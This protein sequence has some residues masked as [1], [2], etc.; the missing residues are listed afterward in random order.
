M[1]SKYHL[2]KALHSFFHF[3]KIIERFAIPSWEVVKSTTGKTFDAKKIDVQVMNHEKVHPGIWQI[4]LTTAEF[5][6]TS[7]IRLTLFSMIVNEAERAKYLVAVIRMFEIR[8][9]S[10]VPLS[11]SIPLPKQRFQCLLKC[12]YPE[13]RYLHYNRVNTH[14]YCLGRHTCKGE[15]Y[16]DQQLGAV[17]MKFAFAPRPE[18]NKMKNG[19]V[20][21]TSSSLF[22]LFSS[23]CLGPFKDLS[24]RHNA[25]H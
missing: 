4:V 8:G 22:D 5:L 10:V 3:L 15:G 24:T 16:S 25:Q 18:V 23:V 20:L 2:T 11:Y 9:N 7:N 21:R 6:V 13:S 1:P 17:I 12:D 19:F 14:H